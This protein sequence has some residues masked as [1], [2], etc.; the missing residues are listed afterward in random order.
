MASTTAAGL[1]QRSN[2]SK[3][4]KAIQTIMLQPR[5]HE[6]NFTYLAGSVTGKSTDAAKTAPT[7]IL[8]LDAQNAHT[9][10]YRGPVC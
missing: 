3:N 9:R 8:L 1:E 7:T 10:S 5:Q 6:V 2:L 4:S